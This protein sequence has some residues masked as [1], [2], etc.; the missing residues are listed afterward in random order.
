MD[1]VAL[2]ATP[3]FRT[4]VRTLFDANQVATVNTRWIGSSAQKMTFA[5]LQGRHA[6]TRGR[7]ERILRK[8]WINVVV[9]A[10]LQSGSLTAGGVRPHR[11]LRAAGNRCGFNAA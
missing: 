1:P 2:G 10:F 8:C 6:R 11:A 7:A 4:V 3:R 5:P 9:P